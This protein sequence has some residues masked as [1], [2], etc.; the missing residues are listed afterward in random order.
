MSPLSNGSFKKVADGRRNLNSVRL[1]GEV[2]GVEEAH[3]RI[4]EV[5][6]KRLGPLWQEER[7]V[8]APH[9]QERRL[10]SAEIFLERWVERYIALVVPKQVEL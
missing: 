10:V 3:H 7:V 5:A 9:R 8:L 6:C 1:E 2:A 4:W